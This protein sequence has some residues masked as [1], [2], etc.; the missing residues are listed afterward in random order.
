M[1]RGVRDVAGAAGRMHTSS[2]G[3]IGH[4][5]W[6]CPAFAR[7]AGVLSHTVTEES[8][9][10]EVAGVS[11]DPPGALIHAQ[12]CCLLPLVKC[13]F[14]S[15]AHFLEDSVLWMPLLGRAPHE[16]FLPPRGL[17]FPW[18]FSRAEVFHLLTSA[19]PVCVHG[20]CFWGCV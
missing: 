14:A 11:G 9:T 2:I 13:L 7:V 19:L 3:H 12:V 20:F 4:V 10:P 16:D 15:A 8:A 17:S 5:G 18:C 6:M 1:A